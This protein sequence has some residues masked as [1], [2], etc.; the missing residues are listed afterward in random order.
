[1]NER[2]KELVKQAGGDFWQ[3]IESDGVLNKEAYITFDPPPSLE[4]FAELII[5]ETLQVARAG[6]EFGPSMEEAVHTY[7]GVEL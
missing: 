5:K 3:R 4:K 6:L 2:I 7:F 1:M